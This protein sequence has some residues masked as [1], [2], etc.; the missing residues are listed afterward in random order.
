R[1]Y[2]SKIKFSG[3]VSKIE[4]RDLLTGIQDYTQSPSSQNYAFTTFKV[5]FNWLVSQQYLDRNP[6][7]AINRP[8]QA[9]RRE[10]YISEAELGALL[11][12]LKATPGCFHDLV[13]LL[14]LTGQS[15]VAP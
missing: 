8:N 9:S 6:L 14:I 5:F 10:R 15:D 2:L 1:L 4:R 3:P 7:L 11:R 12:H 13:Q